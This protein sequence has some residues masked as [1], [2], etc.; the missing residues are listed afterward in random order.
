MFFSLGGAEGGPRRGS[1]MYGAEPD[2]HLAADSPAQAP[3]QADPPAQVESQGAAVGSPGAT[4]GTG[5]TG[6]GLE[7]DPMHNLRLEA[8]RSIVPGFI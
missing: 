4:G 6:G 7:G 8:A 3:A 2:F 5:G 1:A